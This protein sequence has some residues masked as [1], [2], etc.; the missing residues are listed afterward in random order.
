MGGIIFFV[1]V[2]GGFV[3]AFLFFRRM[4]VR[5]SR[6]VGAPGARRTATFRGGMWRPDT[7][8]AAPGTMSLNFR[9]G[10]P[11]GQLGRCQLGRH[12]PGEALYAGV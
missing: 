8:N 5:G 2:A 1:V 7:F 3:L 6:R 12:G 9:L 4:A 10:D 11:L